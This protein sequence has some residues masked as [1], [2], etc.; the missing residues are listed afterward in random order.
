MLQPSKV[1]FRL[2]FQTLSS[3]VLR[4]LDPIE[5]L[6]SHPPFLGD[7]SVEARA[8][9]ICLAEALEDAERHHHDFRSSHHESWID[10]RLRS[11]VAWR[12][13]YP[14]AK[15]K[16]FLWFTERCRKACVTMM[17]MM[18]L[19]GMTF[20]FSLNYTRKGLDLAVSYF[21]TAVKDPVP[22]AN[23][24]LRGRA[25]RDPQLRGEI[26][27]YSAFQSDFPP[28]GR[29][30]HSNHIILRVLWRDQGVIVWLQM[31]AAD[32]QPKVRYSPDA[33]PFAMFT[34]LITEKFILWTSTH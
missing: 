18:I 24:Q 17:V 7:I 13:R 5:V 14:R 10:F 6:V 26:V 34:C 31:V 27:P 23:W 19:L 20:L 16:A 22:F 25:L 4:F 1:S 29:T 32:R 11:S 15:L 8:T 21:L 2:V 28:I 33:S 12:C 9:A 30:A 3:L